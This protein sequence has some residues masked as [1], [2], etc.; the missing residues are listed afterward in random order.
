MAISRWCGGWPATAARSPNR[1]TPDAPLSPLP[2][3]TATT[4]S[5]PSSPPPRY[6]QPSRSWWRAALPTTPKRT[7]RSGR[8]DPCRP[9]PLRRTRRCQCAPEGQDALRLGSPDICPVTRRLVHDAIGPW[10]PFRH[11]LFHAGVRTHIRM[12]M[13]SGNRVR[14]RDHVPTELWRLICSFFLR[15]DWEAPVA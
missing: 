11:F 12:V 2:R 8:L 13:L 9:R 7:L 14:N 6:G 5:S 15:S 10:T 4:A 1:I 3:A